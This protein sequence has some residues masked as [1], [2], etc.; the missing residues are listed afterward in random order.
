MSKPKGSADGKSDAGKKPVKPRAPRR[1][2]AVD[3]AIQAFEKNLEGKNVTVG[4]YLRLVQLRKEID[5]DEPKD[6]ECTWVEQGETK[7]S[8]K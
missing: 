8:D 3:K 4:D 6:I 5:G 7:S 2:N 1:G